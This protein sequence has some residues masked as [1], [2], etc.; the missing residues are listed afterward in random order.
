MIAYTFACY[1]ELPHKDDSGFHYEINNGYGIARDEE[2]ARQHAEARGKTVFSPEEGWEKHQ[3]GI[4]VI[5]PEKILTP[6]GEDQGYVL[7]LV[8]V[9]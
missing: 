7:K 1:T 4:I 5:H 8:P 9:Q 6:I 3:S 2:E